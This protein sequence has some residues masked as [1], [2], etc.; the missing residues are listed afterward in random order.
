LDKQRLT[1]Y[2]AKGAL[3][4]IDDATPLLSS[5]AARQESDDGNN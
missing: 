4:R 2:F 5:E 3:T 1:L